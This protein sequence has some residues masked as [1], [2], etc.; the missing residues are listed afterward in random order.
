MCTG[1]VLD[2]Q[3]GAPLEQQLHNLLFCLVCGPVQRRPPLQ[4]VL[5]VDVRAPLQQHHHDVPVSFARRPVE[6]RQATL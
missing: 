2:L 5:S 6:R 1:V 3:V 4:L